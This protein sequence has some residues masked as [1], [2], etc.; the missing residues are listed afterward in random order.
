[1]ALPPA[2]VLTVEGKQPNLKLVCAISIKSERPSRRASITIDVL[3]GTGVAIMQAEPRVE[4]FIGGPAGTYLWDLALDLP[5]LVPG[6][7]FLT[8]W[9]GP[10]NTET[11]D[12]VRQAVQ[13]EVFESP[14]LGTTFPHAADHGSVVPF[15]TV[16]VRT[17]ADLA[18]ST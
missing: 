8:F 9:K 18:Q 15:S 3:D 1:M 5:P 14:T 2:T 12:C 4:P 17:E 6:N 10:H 16:F 7:Y 11:F 13:F